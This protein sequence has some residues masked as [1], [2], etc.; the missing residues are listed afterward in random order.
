MA[1]Q[2]EKYTAP[3]LDKG[4]DILEAL[5][6]ADAGLTQAEIARQLDRSVS[7]IF[8]MLVVL[9]RRG[10]VALDK[11]SD[12]YT[13]TTRLFELANR[14]PVV[15]QLSVAAGPILW[16]LARKVRQSVHLAVL[17]GDSIVVVAQ[18]D[19]PGNNVL[20]VRLG[21][22]IEIWRTS[23]GRV[24]LAF[25]PKTVLDQHLR[26]YPHPDG[27]TPS[28]IRRDLDEIRAA[29]IETMPSFIIKGVTNLSAP[30]I[31]HTG[32]ATAAL[33]IPMIG[34]YFG[35]ISVAACRD[36]LLASA[37]ELSRRIGGNFE[38]PA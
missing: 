20:S 2:T 1:T 27:R 28:D 19:N 21:A 6:E 23:S 32:H 8:R 29:R 35:G 9:R 5:A 37:A 22:R 31:D 33:T 16:D 24:I 11:R 34:R 3:A 12:L 36:E 30:V 14:T 17:S 4:F 13:L 7:E 25:Q 15:R 10:L 38:A 18:V 26:D